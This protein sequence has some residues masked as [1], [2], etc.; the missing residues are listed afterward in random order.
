MASMNRV[1]VLWS[2]WAG[3]PGV[4]TFYLADGRLDVTP[5]K[6]FFTAMAPFLPTPIQWTI[7]SIGDKI[8]DGD[9]TIAGSWIGTGGGVVPTTGINSPYSGASGFCVDWKTG[10][11]VNGR[12]IQGRTF[13]VPGAQVLYQNDGTIVEATRGT[14]LAAATALISSLGTDFLIWARPFEPGPDNPAPGEP[15]H[16]EPRLGTSGPVAAAFVPD[17]A[18][19]LRSRRV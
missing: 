19:V 7:P 10:T 8:A 15:G 5:I 11:I 16:K 17:L 14:I 4:S 6:T 13:F 3:Q 9:G 18:V 12:R 2:N 1:R